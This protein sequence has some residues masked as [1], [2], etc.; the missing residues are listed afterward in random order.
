MT[1][2]DRLEL[3]A[4]ELSAVLRKATAETQRAVSLAVCNFAMSRNGLIHPALQEGIHAIREGRYGDRRVA[5]LLK[6]LVEE[7][8]EK[9]FDLQDAADD[10]DDPEAVAAF[11]RARTAN[12]FLFAVKED[13]HEAATEAAYEAHA[14]TEDLE[15]L[16][17]TILASL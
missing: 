4:P 1:S 3:I 12:A 17:Q 7:L 9:Y 11:R 2:E 14:A 5:D 13:A 15:G 16:R 10:S 6:R 8:D